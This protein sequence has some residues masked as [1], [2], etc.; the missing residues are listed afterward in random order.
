MANFL[1]LQ[2]EVR[3]NLIDLPTVV[4][5]SVPTLVKRAVERLHKKH[6]FKVMEAEQSYTTVL[7]TRSIGAVPA[8]FRENRGAPYRISD[9]DGH[10]TPLVMAPERTSIIGAY[11]EDDEGAPAALLDAIPSGLNVRNYHV[12][13]LPDGNSDYSDGEYRIVV[14]YWKTL[15][16]LSANGD[17]NWFTIN[18]DEWIVYTATA[19]GFIK[20]WDEERG[21]YWKQLATEVLGEVI[22]QDKKYRLSQVD[23][24]VPHHEGFYSDRLSR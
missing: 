16:V 2:T 5:N 18:A 14:P 22:K 9:V 17:T 3:E 4:T 1:E 11:T 10:T 6:N 21:V 20:D 8:D 19:Y 15:P 13:P 12:F 24:L 7:A 23:T